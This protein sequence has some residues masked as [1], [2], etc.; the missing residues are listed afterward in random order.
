MMR[1]LHGLCHMQYRLYE[2]TSDGRRSL[3]MALPEVFGSIMEKMKKRTAL[4]I[5]W[6]ICCDS[7]S[8]ACYA[9]FVTQ[10]DGTFVA[11]EN[12]RAFRESILGKS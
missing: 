3:K 12:T 8:C 2:A 7:V 10:L 4:S 6:N 9:A 5:F 11:R 1:D